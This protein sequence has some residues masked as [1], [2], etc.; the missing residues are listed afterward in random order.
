MVATA[1]MAVVAI[2]FLA[3][4]TN[5]YLKKSPARICMVKIRPRQNFDKGIILLKNSSLNNYF[6]FIMIIFIANKIQLQIL[7]PF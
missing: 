4:T 3:N 5:E 7:T 6:I 1:I 2:D